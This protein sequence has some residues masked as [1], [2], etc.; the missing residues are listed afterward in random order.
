MN[1]V[2]EGKAAKGVQLIQQGIEK[3]GLKRPEDAKLHLGEAQ[4]IAGAQGQG[5]GRPSRR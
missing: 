5:A 1:Y 3:G 4:L 2:Y